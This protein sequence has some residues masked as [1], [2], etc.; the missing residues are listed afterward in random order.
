MT[1]SN[2]SLAAVVIIGALYLMVF[3]IALGV[4]SR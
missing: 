2:L 3:L 4:I 1:E